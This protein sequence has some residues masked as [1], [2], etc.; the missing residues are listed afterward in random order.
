MELSKQS[1]TKKQWNVTYTVWNCKKIC[2][3]KHVTGKV[4][5]IVGKILVRAETKSTK[6]GINLDHMGQKI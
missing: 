3:R 6:I 4:V 1:K 2:V 5:M